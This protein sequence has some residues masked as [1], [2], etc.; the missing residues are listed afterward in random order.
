M[1]SEIVKQPTKREL[2]AKHRRFAELCAEGM[3]HCRA[4]REV[5]PNASQS[6]AEVESCRLLRKP[7][8][9]A[10]YQKLLGEV[11]AK[12]EVTIE[13]A[14]RQLKDVAENG[15]NSDRVA[16]IAQLSKM[17]GWYAPT[18]TDSTIDGGISIASLIKDFDE[19][20]NG[21]AIDFE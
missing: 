9:A 19:E 15:R 5:F 1:S 17:N 16:A 18:K 4:Y 14:H 2:S 7:S 21:P 20:N 3:T 12:A 8:V 11:S 13:W 6:T 10:Y